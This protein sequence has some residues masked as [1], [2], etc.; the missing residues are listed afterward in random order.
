M[1][2][3]SSNAVYNAISMKNTEHQVGSWLGIPMYEK[4]IK[5]NI[6]TY[7]TQTY[8][9]SSGTGVTGIVSVVDIRGICIKGSYSNPT[10]AMV[11]PYTFMSS[12][13][14]LNIYIYYNPAG[15]SFQI[16]V[17]GTYQS[18]YYSGCELYITFKYVK[19]T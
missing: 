11:V 4:T 17:G 8:S 16:T 10:W 18:G 12:N 5:V 13:L 9:T 7:T 3:V 19:S 2:S 6:P 1:Q 15:N 14:Y